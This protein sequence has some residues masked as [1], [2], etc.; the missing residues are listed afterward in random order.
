MKRLVFILLCLAS[1]SSF[2]THNRAGEITYRL[3][4]GLTYEITITTYTKQSS[5]ADRCDLTVYFGDG[6][7]AIFYRING[8]SFTLC[9]TTIPDGENVGTDI[10][11]NIYR[12]QHTYPAPYTYRISMQDPNRVADINNIPNSVNVPFALETILVINSILGANS[13]P[14]LLNPPIDNACTNV[15]FYHNPG[16]YDPD[17]DSLSYSLTS[18]IVSAGTPILGYTVP[19]TS[20]TIFIDAVTG[21]FEWCTPTST[22]IYN[23]AILIDEW[24]KVGTSVFKVGS[25]LRDMQI[26]VS[27]CN[28]NPPVIANIIDTCIE[29]RSTLTMT[30][31]AT[32]PNGDNL[33]LSA[34]G[35]PMSAVPPP[36]ATFPL[37]IGPQPLSAVFNWTT[38]CEH[39]RSQ[40]YI[41]SFKAVDVGNPNL[42][43]FETVKIT[44]IAPAPKNPIAAPS[45]T[46]MNIR[47]SPSICNPTNNKFIGY[48][49]YRKSGA[50]GW[51]PGHCETGVPAYTGFVKIADRSLS[52]G[53]TILDT[54]YT[55]NNN[56]AGLIHGLTYC[57]R[58][59]AYFKDG[60]ESYSS[61]ETCAE[62]INDV[63]IITNV[64]VVST[65]TNDTIFIKW[66]KPVVGPVDFDTVA[67]PGPYQFKIYQSRG[68]NLANPVLIHTYTSP[69]FLS[70]NDSTYTSVSLNTRDSAY[71]YRVDF[72]SNGNLIG[73]SH[74]ASSV[75]L[76]INPS[77][78]Q[79]TLNWQA[80]VPWSN[81]LYYIYK[82]IAGVY[83]L[84][85]STA[86]TLYVDNGLV[87]GTEYCYYIESK[88]EYSDPDIEKPL[89]NTSERKCGTPIDLIPPCAPQLTVIP[90]CD[91]FEDFL[92]WNNPNNVCSDDAM[93]YKIYYT[94][95]QGETPVI[96]ATV[97]NLADTTYIYSNQTSIAGC[98]AVTAVDSSGNESPITSMFCVDNCPI[99]ELPNVFTPNFDGTND[100]FTPL[101]P[102]RYI[103]DIDIKIY[104][105]WGLLMFSTT[106]PNINW[107]GKNMDT[108][109]LCVDGTY[110]YT[111][112]V[113]QIRVNGIVP[114]E[115]KGF[116]QIIDGNKKGSNN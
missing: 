103:K 96:I 86:S 2:A 54:T 88:G 82:E 18:S 1:L 6:D 98:F 114:R 26:D 20:S 12:G 40:P 28:N 81:K 31:T 116:I 19:P 92:R 27:A 90:N 21:D 33:T 46:S 73:N 61:V 4:S 79:L 106:D 104:D 84:Y 57:Y 105:R 36:L 89:F 25:V 39:V 16:A 38:D 52:G 66:K 68:F 110:F 9:G 5:P 58:I 78:N 69:V 35:G 56:G 41:V 8:T 74:I 29:A 15:C 7:S 107:D 37:T 34:T 102:Y 45:G 23:I 14:V 22:G 101:R 64:D 30:V 10:K 3:V 55:D 113:N 17:G 63:P 13:S 50:T 42:V 111:C 99:Y 11:K 60:A 24:R 67:N 76:N 91:A 72:Y 109:K 108:G 71:S 77:D 70:W 75:Y 87:N 80:N 83:T 43:D 112:T 51:S 49:I 44:V 65:G 85:D 100:K 53:F 94:P 93:F 115:L 32:D 97:N 47:W 48:R 59:V 62:L 95:I